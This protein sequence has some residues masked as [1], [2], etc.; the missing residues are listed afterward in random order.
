L[1]VVNVGGTGKFANASGG[2]TLNFH[3]AYFNGATPP[4][5]GAM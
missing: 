5:V 4:S 3:P 1:H 2:E